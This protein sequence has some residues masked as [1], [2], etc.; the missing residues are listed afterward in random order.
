MIGTGVQEVRGAKVMPYRGAEHGPLMPGALA[1]VFSADGAPVEAARLM[2]HYMPLRHHPDGRTPHV[3]D[4]A[5]KPFYMTRDVPAAGAVEALMGAYIFAGPLFDHFGHF[6]LES[7]SR[8]WFIKSRP[9]LPILWCP[10]SGQGVIKPWMRAILDLLDVKN[11]IHILNAPTMVETLLVADDGYMIQTAMTELQRAA[12]AVYPAK[13]VTR[14][15]KVW[16]S[17]AGLDSGRYLNDDV[18][19]RLLARSGWTLFRPEDHALPDQLAMLADAE[20]IA[21]VEG[22]AFHSLMFISGLRA[23]VDIIP[24]GRLLSKN[25]TTL[26]AACGFDQYVHYFPSVL[27]SD[28]L[29][30]W[31]SNY[32]WLG[33][34]PILKA[35]DVTG[36]APPRLPLGLADR[37][38]A[39]LR[40]GGSMLVESA[41]VFVCDDSE[42]MTRLVR[43]RTLVESGA[44]PLYDMSFDAFVRAG[45]AHGRR[46][47]TLVFLAPNHG[48]AFDRRITLALSV[49]APEG[50]LWCVCDTSGGQQLARALPDHVVRRFGED[51]WSL[52]T[53][54][55][56]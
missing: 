33:L 44:G 32:L 39:R 29:P 47:D 25:F 49:L 54:S 20:R 51:E 34:D 31:K 7:L 21:G 16:L 36:A 14:G 17:R 30:G 3:D 12:F 42:Q 26:A 41:D 18:L 10:V 40:T 5:R 45:L 6:L 46:Y 9:D 4:A 53:A 52:Y 19:E 11:P 13:P 48:P 55:R 56:S 50:E 15:K 28:N 22:S 35:L 38:A 8:L 24:R 23:R 43:A 37:L 27:W 1:G 2:R